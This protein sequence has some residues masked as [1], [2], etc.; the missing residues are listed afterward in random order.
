MDLLNDTVLLKTKNT[1]LNVLIRET[2]QYLCYER[3]LNLTYIVQMYVV[4]K[5]VFFGKMQFWSHCF[6]VVSYQAL[7]RLSVYK[8]PTVYLSGAKMCVFAR[9]ATFRIPTVREKSV[10]NEKNSRSGKSQ[11]ILNLVREI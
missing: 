5:N 4:Y 10:K 6:T 8:S 9:Y 1:L 3:L 11:G 7:F 2:S